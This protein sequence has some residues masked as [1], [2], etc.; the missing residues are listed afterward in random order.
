MSS[1]SVNALGQPRLTNPTLGVLVSGEATS[2]IPRLSQRPRSG[3][4]SREITC[5][6]TAYEMSRVS[7]LFSSGQTTEQNAQRFFSELHFDSE[8]PQH[9]LGLLGHLLLHLVEDVLGLL[10]VIAHHP[11]HHGV[12][13]AHE[14]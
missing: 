7:R 6:A 12:L 4:G 3:T 13:H 8:G 9:L 14:L 11:L 10:D 1:E 2:L 5:G